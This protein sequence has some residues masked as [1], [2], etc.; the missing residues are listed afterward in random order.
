MS[1][2]ELAIGGRDIL[3]IQ[4]L[5]VYGDQI[6]GLCNERGTL[7]STGPSVAPR[8]CIFVRNTVQ[9]FSLSVLSSRT[10]T[11]WESCEE[12]LKVK[13]EMYQELHAW[14]GM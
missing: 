2:W 5:W 1:Y 6:R 12:D 14:C 3:L 13:W 8:A 10:R 4:E 9:A 7:C 11:N